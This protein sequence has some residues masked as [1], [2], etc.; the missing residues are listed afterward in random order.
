LFFVGAGYAGEPI[1]KVLKKFVS[2]NVGIL[3]RWTVTFNGKSHGYTPAMNNYFGIGVDAQITHKF[4]TMREKNPEQFQNRAMN[5]VK[6]VAYGATAQLKN[7]AQ[8]LELFCDGEKVAVPENCQAI[9]VLN[10]ESYAAGQKLWDQSETRDFGPASVGDG[11]LEVVSLKGLLFFLFF[12]F[13]FSQ[14]FF[15]LQDRPISDWRRW[16]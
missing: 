5:K 12:L 1:K 15:L 2:A 10:I 9:A 4:H 7:L 14:L 6:Y 13:H 11:K 3:D 8:D 16:V